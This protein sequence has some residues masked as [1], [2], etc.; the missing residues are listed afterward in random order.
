MLNH[1]RRNNGFKRF[2]VLGKLH[3]IILDP[4]LIK[5]QRWIFALGHLNTL[6]IV[7]N[8]DGLKASRCELRAQST[9]SGPQIQNS[10]HPKII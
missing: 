6:C 7:L 2:F 10:S 9:I 5:V 1:F 4:E 3:R 8:P